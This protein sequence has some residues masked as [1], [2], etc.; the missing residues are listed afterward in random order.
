MQALIDDRDLSRGRKSR[1]APAAEA[2]QRAASHL[3]EAAAAARGAGVAQ[4]PRAEGAAVAAP[5]SADSGGPAREPA[6]AAPQLGPPPLQGSGW[7]WFGGDLAAVAAQFAQASGAQAPRVYEEAFFRDFEHFT[8]KYP[9]HNAALKFFVEQLEDPADP[10]NSTGRR[11]DPESPAQIAAIV[12]HVSGPE[13]EF[14][15]T[16]EIPWDWKEMVAQLRDQDLRLV[17]QGPEGR[18]RGLVGC[19]VWPRPNSYDHLRQRVLGS[20]HKLPCWDFVL[21][22]DD[23]TGIRLHPRRTAN[24]VETFEVAGHPEPVQ[25]PWNGLGRSDGPGTVRWYKTIDRGTPVRFDGAK[26][27]GGGKGKGRGK[28][29][30]KGQGRGS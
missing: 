4:G 5:S 21:H 9:Q 23:G 8:G 26:Q 22:R 3:E 12:P 7:A 6:P 25:T 1:A 2:W 30:G 27:P 24:K 17:V 10:Q 18:S 29:K 13:W 14:D 19:D 28:G 16:K 15:R 20:P 11:F